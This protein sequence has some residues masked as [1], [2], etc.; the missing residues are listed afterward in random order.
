VPSSV[1][2]ILPNTDFYQPHA[3]C[4]ISYCGIG[5]T[6]LCLIGCLIPVSNSIY[7]LLDTSSSFAYKFLLG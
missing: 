5:T 2:K 7:E 4:S 6:K 1:W 3:T